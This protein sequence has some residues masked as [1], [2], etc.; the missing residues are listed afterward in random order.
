MENYGRPVLHRTSR[1][2]AAIFLEL[3]QVERLVFWVALE[4]TIKGVAGIADGHIANQRIRQK[5]HHGGQ[6]ERT[7]GVHRQ[8]ARKEVDTGCDSYADNRESEPAVKIFLDIECV[9]TARYTGCNDT[10]IED[11]GIH[12]NFNQLLAM[13]AR[14]PVRL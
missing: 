2:T 6:P 1:I 9:M 13:G 5:I 8:A 4:T 7:H 10:A 11:G 14:H 12:E 3:F